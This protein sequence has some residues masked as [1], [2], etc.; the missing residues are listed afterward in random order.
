MDQGTAATIQAVAS[1]VNAV[2][3]LVLIGVTVFYVRATKRIATQTKQQAEASVRMAEEM[4]ETR[5]LSYRPVLVL[6]SVPHE[7]N[8]SYISV[9]IQNIGNGPAGNVAV[10]CW[11]R[12][13]YYEYTGPSSLASRETRLFKAVR[14]NPGQPIIQLN[15]SV[16]Q[17]DVESINK[18]DRL[19]VAIASL[20]FEGKQIG[21]PAAFHVGLDEMQAQGTQ[22]DQTEITGNVFWA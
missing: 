2:L 21:Q 22:I 11:W 7:A 8:E 15:G 1:A 17:E 20:D 3:V 18:G 5:E 10:S 12:N 9:N 4:K 6:W 16:R 14:V 19:L 13:R